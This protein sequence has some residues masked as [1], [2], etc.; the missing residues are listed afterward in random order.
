[1]RFDRAIGRPRSTLSCIGTASVCKDL[2]APDRGIF[3]AGSDEAC[4]KRESLTDHENGKVRL[5]TMYPGP[6]EA[7][8]RGIGC[9]F[10]YGVTSAI[11]FL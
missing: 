10:T 8:S 7:L 3:Q 5:A 11:S 9:D 2:A 1:M 4:R 6:I